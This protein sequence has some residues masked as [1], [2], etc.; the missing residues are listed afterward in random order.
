[1]KYL[2]LIYGNEAAME[3]FGANTPPDQQAAEAKV[4][5]E[6]GDWL[7]EKGWYLA[8]EAL[9]PTA[10]ATSVRAPDGKPI[11]TDGPFAETKEQLGGY[12]VIEAADLDEAL[13][14][15]AQIPEAQIGGVEVRPIMDFEGMDA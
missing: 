7:R 11:V 8:G 12:Y 6:Y 10:T 2:L 14:W 4:W 9:Q 15:A 1:M 5:Y 13:G 3:A